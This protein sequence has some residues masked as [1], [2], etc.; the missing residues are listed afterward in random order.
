MFT[1]A[2]YLQLHSY[3]VFH[4]LL[5]EQVF[6]IVQAGREMIDGTQQP[7]DRRAAPLR[8]QQRMVISVAKLPNN[9]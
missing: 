3:Y 7:S 2:D 4:Q 9:H 8:K 6:T 1:A 5:N